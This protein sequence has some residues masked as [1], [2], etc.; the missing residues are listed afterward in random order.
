MKALTATYLN[1]LKMIPISL[2]ALLKILQICMSKSRFESNQYL[3][4]ISP[5]TIHLTLLNLHNKHGKDYFYQYGKLHFQI[6][7]YNCHFFFTPLGVQWSA[8]LRVLLSSILIPFST[9]HLHC[10]C[11]VV[12]II[13]LFSF[14]IDGILLFIEIQHCGFRLLSVMV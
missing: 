2:D 1:L 7:K 13:I 10:I 8:A 14:T 11:I 3:S 9:C 4:L 5:A 6:L 12:I